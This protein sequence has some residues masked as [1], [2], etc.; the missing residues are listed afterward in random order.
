MP[1]L[2]LGAFKVGGVVYLWHGNG[3]I[4]GTGSDERMWQGPFT[5]RLIA[6][7]AK[8]GDDDQEIPAILDA[9]EED[10]SVANTPVSGPGAYPGGSDALHPLPAAQFKS[11]KPAGN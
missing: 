7:V 1:A 8:A 2:P 5:Q 4:R 3:V 6:D 9:I 11:F 10:P